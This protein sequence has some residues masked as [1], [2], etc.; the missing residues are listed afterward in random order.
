MIIV[1]NKLNR[2]KEKEGTRMINKLLYPET[3]TSHVKH[4]INY[5]MYTLKKSQLRLHID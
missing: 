2:Y 1:V 4:S 5:V 3:H